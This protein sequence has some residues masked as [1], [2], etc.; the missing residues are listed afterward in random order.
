[1]EK[2]LQIWALECPYRTGVPGRRVNSLIKNVCLHHK[3][4]QMSF[5]S[6]V[7]KYSR[8]FIG[9]NLKDRFVKRIVLRIFIL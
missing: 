1:M 2:Q 9:I 3:S 4:D 6:E 7:Q 8:P 5:F